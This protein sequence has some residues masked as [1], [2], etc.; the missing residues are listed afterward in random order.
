ANTA[1]Q[2]DAKN[3]ANAILFATINIPFADQ[4]FADP[5]S[6]TNGG[7]SSTG[8]IAVVAATGGSGGNLLPLGNLSQSYC[9]RYQTAPTFEIQD[10]PKPAAGCTDNMAWNEPSNDYTMLLLTAVAVK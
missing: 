6:C 1:I 4:D 3:S 2:D 5:Q 9:W 10:A 7:G 8:A